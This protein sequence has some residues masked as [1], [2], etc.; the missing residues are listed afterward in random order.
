MNIEITELEGVMV[1][2]PDDGL[3]LLGYQALAEKINALIPS[4]AK[5]PWKIVLDLGAVTYVSS[6]VVNVLLGAGARAR[7][8]GGALALAQVRGG[9]KVALD[10][11]GTLKTLSVYATVEDAVRA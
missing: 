9:A 5:G 1:L 2:R 7:A 6:P 11:S 4:G 10:V 3:D 8:S